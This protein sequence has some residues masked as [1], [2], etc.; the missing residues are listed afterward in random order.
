MPRNTTLLDAESLLTLDFVAAAW[1]RPPAV[2]LRDMLATAKRRIEARRSGNGIA[3]SD[4]GNGLANAGCGLA[5][6]EDADA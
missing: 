5:N 4:L 3:V 2:V 6:I 1:G